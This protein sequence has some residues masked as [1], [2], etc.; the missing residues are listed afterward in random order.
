MRFR[1]LLVAVAAAAIA[2][3]AVPAAGAL[4]FPDDVCPVRSGTVIKVCPTGETGKAYSYQ[5]KGRD[6]TG[7]VPYV[8]WKAAG[9]PP[10]LSIDSGSGMISGVPTQTG[11]YVFWVT[12][13]DV[14]N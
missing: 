1:L 3:I 2:C 4:T 11:T 9:L 5:L 12:M 7:C 14:K 6:G 8:I 10:G 13:T